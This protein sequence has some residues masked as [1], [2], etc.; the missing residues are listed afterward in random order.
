[1]AANESVICRAAE[2]PVYLP[3]FPR[4]GRALICCRV[5]QR[6]VHAAFAMHSVHTTPSE[7][8]ISESPGVILDAS[9]M[10]W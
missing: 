4:K 7:W 6:R 10:I 8:R 5:L 9:T 3:V 2:A 1:V